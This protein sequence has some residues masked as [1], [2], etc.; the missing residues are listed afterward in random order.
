MARG[1]ES[2]GRVTENAEWKCFKLQPDGGLEI[3]FVALFVASVSIHPI[4]NNIVESCSYI[5]EY[6]H[7]QIE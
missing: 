6:I 3:K 2:T 1:L 7:P 4:L 5:H